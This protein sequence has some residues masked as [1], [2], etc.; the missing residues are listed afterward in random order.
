MY[1]LF[2]YLLFVTLQTP[3]FEFISNAK[4]SLFAYPAPLKPPTTA[5]VEKVYILYNVVFTHY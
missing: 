3:K 1:L 4:P 5:V 2:T